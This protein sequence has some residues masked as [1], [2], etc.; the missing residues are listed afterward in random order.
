MP[1]ADSPTLPL[2]EKSGVLGAD[3][4]GEELGPEANAL[5]LALQSTTDR[6]VLSTQV[7]EIAERHDR[8][9]AFDPARA[10]VLRALDLPASARV[11]EVTD[12]VGVTSRY[13]A[14]TCAHV[15]VLAAHAESAAIIAARLSDCESARVYVG[16]ATDSPPR[17]KYDVVVALADP[18]APPEWALTE[19]ALRTLITHA[20]KVL[21][22]GGSIVLGVTNPLGVR[23]LAGARDEGT[24]NPFDSIEGYPDSPGR[25]LLTRRL[26]AQVAANAGL[27]QLTLGVFPDHLRARTVLA[28][29]VFETSPLLALQ[30]P[31]FTP[32]ASS[33]HGV[34]VADESHLWSSLHQTG[35]AHEFS[36]AWLAVMTH[37]KN[38]KSPLWPKRRLA[39]LVNTDRAEEFMTTVTFKDSRDSGPVVKRQLI[40]GAPQAESKSVTW[41]GG[42][43]YLA[44]GRDLDGVLWDDPNRARL[45]REWIALIPEQGPMP[46]DLVPWNIIATADRLVPI[47]QEWTST[48]YSRSSVIARGV[49]FSVTR[50]AARVSI[51]DDRTT[52][53]VG[54]VA[55]EWSSEAGFDLSEDVI[56]QLISDEATFQLHTRGVASDTLG[57]EIRAVLDAPLGSL[58][59]QER[60]DVKVGALES[61]LDDTTRYARHLEARIEADAAHPVRAFARTVPALRHIVSLNVVRKLRARLVA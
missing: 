3:T 50:R 33:E 40:S 17:H 60:L 25:A 5:V 38:K 29:R 54:D 15:D 31:R 23:Y 41:T 21:A 32:H 11:L 7:S 18:E 9:S 48:E 45:L 16:A 56:A 58:Q 35:A 1:S 51:P 43:E 14:D 55:R 10:N 27:R 2:L 6:S 12:G 52:A 53:T 8:V 26:L 47:D 4:R 57:D 37:N 22:S 61:A 44:R 39:R 13:L 24:G 42:R 36:N 34:R 49:I 46:V 28:P 30:L 19:Q 20:A 59:G